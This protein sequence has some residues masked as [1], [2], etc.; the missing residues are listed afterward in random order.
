M[1]IN[2]VAI[3]PN[4]T[5]QLDSVNLLVLSKVVRRSCRRDSTQQCQHYHSINFMKYFTCKKKTCHWQGIQASTLSVGY[6]ACP[7]P[8]AQNL[9]ELSQRVP[10]CWPMVFWAVPME[11]FDLMFNLMC[12]DDLYFPGDTQKL[13][14][15]HLKYGGHLG[16]QDVSNRYRWHDCSRVAV[17]SYPFFC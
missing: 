17:S 14:M 2:Q 5:V 9:W 3:Y 16:F 7:R 13:W 8:V 10:W 4:A 1:L 6:G 15:K 12:T 11:M